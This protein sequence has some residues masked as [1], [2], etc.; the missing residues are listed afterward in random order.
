MKQC[1][2][3]VSLVVRDYE[4]ALEFFVGVLGF[5]LIEDS[6][7][8]AQAKRWVVIVPPGASESRLLLARASTEEQLSRVGTQT[9]GRV[10]LFL[11]TDDFWRDYEKYRARGVCFVREPKREP[12]G[13]VAVF[14]DLYGNL[15]DLIEPAPNRSAEQTSTVVL[16]TSE[17]YD[18]WASCYDT[19]GNPILALEEPRVD[20]LLGDV[21]GLALLDVGCGTG[22][23][24]I[25]LARA[26]AVVQAVDFSTGMVQQA[27]QKPGAENVTFRVHDLSQPLPFGEGEFDR[28]ICGLVVDH[29]G[30]LHGLF[31]EMLRVC[32]PSGRVVVSVMHPA[33]ML[34]GVQARFHDAERKQEIRPASHEHQLSDYVLA[35]TRAGGALAHLSEHFVTE[36]LATRCE[37]ARKY[38]GWPMLLMMQLSPQR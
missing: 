19:D 35:A 34:R 7:V 15:W 36:E 27:K 6:P 33:M 24:A 26:G 16:P 9:G 20:E 23:H 29:I 2:G 31:S 17:G 28:V 37:R 32:R 5:T 30:N 8:P 11:Q 18:Q 1:L 12:Y 10:F 4:E 25:R 14:K 13:T 21:K 3:L 22:R 38:V